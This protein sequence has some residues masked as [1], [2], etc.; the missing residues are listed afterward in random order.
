MIGW[1]PERERFLTSKPAYS[2][3]V[4]IKGQLLGVLRDWGGLPSRAVVI[5]S[6]VYFRQQ[7]EAL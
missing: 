5:D 3:G 1:T 4:A 6:H 2:E 7:E